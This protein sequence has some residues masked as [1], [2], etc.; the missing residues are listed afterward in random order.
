MLNPYIR[1]YLQG[2]ANGKF[3]KTF[4]TPD[5]YG[6]YKFR[7]Q[8]RRPGYSTLSFSDQVSV[9]PFAHNEYERFILSAYPYY[10]STFSM[11]VGFF[12]FGFGFLYHKD[13]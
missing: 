5:I 13:A 10:I 12:L 6:I 8:Y 11:M 3:S 7:I 9:R 2:D 1:T 4:L